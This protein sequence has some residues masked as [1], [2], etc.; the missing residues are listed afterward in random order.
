MRET[1][2]PRKKLVAKDLRR[3]AQAADDAERERKLLFLADRLESEAD[4]LERAQGAAH[5]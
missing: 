4:A 1:I 3:L 5:E 2:Q